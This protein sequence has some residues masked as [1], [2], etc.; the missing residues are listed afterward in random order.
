[1][2]YEL[3]EEEEPEV[4]DKMMEVI[5]KNDPFELRLKPISQDKC[6]ER[7]NRKIRTCRL[8]GF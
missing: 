2:E 1:M 7:L 8:R 3:K 4:K 6:K 5:K